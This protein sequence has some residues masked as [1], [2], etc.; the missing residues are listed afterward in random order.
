M[1]K[2]NLLKNKGRLKINIGN[3]GC[4]VAARFLDPRL[5]A[6]FIETRLYSNR[7]IVFLAGKVIHF[8]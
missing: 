1:I 2:M 4:L 5:S 8:S 3:L 6:K 7:S